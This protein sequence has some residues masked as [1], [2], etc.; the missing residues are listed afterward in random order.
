[1]RIGYKELSTLIIL[2]SYVLQYIVDSYIAIHRYQ[3]Y[4]LTNS[5][6]ILV[7]RLV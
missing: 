6:C 3:E 2:I 4:I 5:I 1:M 7:K